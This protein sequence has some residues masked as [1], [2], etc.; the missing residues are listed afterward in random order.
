MSRHCSRFKKSMRS[1]F[2]LLLLLLLMLLLPLLFQKISVDKNEV[3]QKTSVNK[4]EVSRNKDSKLVNGQLVL[5][6]TRYM[7]S[8]LIKKWYINSDYYVGTL[9]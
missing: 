4:N 1:R 7:N 5:I 6:K 8:G 3:I 2:I 9:F